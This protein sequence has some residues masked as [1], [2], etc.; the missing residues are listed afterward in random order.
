[1]INVSI[2]LF[3]AIYECQLPDPL[4]LHLVTFLKFFFTLVYVNF[5]SSRCILE[6]KFDSY[7]RAASLPS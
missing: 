1:M 7:H 5:F 2:D 3:V 6:V 4:Y